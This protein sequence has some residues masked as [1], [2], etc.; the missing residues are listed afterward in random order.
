MPIEIKELIVRAVVETNDREQ[1]SR[2]QSSDANSSAELSEEKMEKMMHSADELLGNLN[3][4]FDDNTKGNIKE[5]I[6]DLK[7]ILDNFKATSK[8]IDVLVVRN[9][10]KLNNFRNYEMQLFKIYN[11]NRTDC[12]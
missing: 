5:G 1:P 11:I 7:T 8:S 2:E 4:V 12:F 10:D 6:G 9:K 3:D